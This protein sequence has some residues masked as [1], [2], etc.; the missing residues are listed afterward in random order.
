[1]KMIFGD[2]QD[3][4]SALPHLST[5]IAAKLTKMLDGRLDI[6][7][8]VGSKRLL[9]FRVPLE[10]SRKGKTKDQTG[11]VNRKVNILLVEDHF[12]NQIATKKVLTSW[13]ELVNVVTADNGEEAL[14]QFEK[15]KF[16]LILMDL[17]IPKVSGIEAARIIREKSLV[18][19]IALT[20]SSSKQEEERCFTVGMNDYISKPIKPEEL[21][22][23]ITQLI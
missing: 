22:S 3:E 17:K 14:A 11:V 13:S 12:L 8:Q 9:K 7:T 18:P 23:K 20:A 16:D 21:Y 10:T 15:E 1:M 4:K 5:F 19:I 6:S 2:D